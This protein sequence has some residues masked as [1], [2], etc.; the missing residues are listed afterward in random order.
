M[1]H[2]NNLKF[3]QRTRR[4]FLAIFANNNIRIIL[5]YCGRIILVHC[6]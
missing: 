6:L 3:D 4:V 1:F 2:Y 5:D